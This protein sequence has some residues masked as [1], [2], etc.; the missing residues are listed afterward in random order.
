MLQRP[1]HGLAANP[2]I[3]RGEDESTAIRSGQ[4]G[5]RQMVG[6]K[7]GCQID[8]TSGLRFHCC[9]NR[10]VLL[11]QS[12][13]NRHRSPC[14]TVLRTARRRRTGAGDGLSD[15]NP[16][17]GKRADRMVVCIFFRT[18]RT[19]NSSQR[20]KITVGRHGHEDCRRQLAG[21]QAGARPVSRAQTL[22]WECLRERR[23]VWGAQRGSNP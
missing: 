23:L 3:S 13:L 20:P 4:R 18:R 9:E 6:C 19:G 2:L 11:L 12:V 15:L 1:R 16:I 17:F 21:L 8:P 22:G 7:R 5:W 14:G 10:N